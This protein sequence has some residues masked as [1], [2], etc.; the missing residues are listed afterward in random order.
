M[1]LQLRYPGDGKVVSCSSP[2]PAKDFL[3]LLARE[4]VTLARLQPV[5]GDVHR[6]YR[7]VR[8]NNE[9][10]DLEDYS[11]LYNSDRRLLAVIEPSVPRLNASVQA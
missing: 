7:L 9:L 8:P 11:E 1:T 10:L 5:R 4:A 2:I 6:T 3:H